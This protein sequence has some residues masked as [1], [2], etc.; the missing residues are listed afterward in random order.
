[1]YINN[2][3]DKENCIL[4][5]YVYYALEKMKFNTPEHILSEEQQTILIQALNWETSNLTAENAYHFYLKS[6]GWN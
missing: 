6:I 1:M 4:K 5:G 3:N 2:W